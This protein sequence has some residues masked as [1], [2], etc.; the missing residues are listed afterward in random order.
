[1]SQRCV[2]FVR[3]WCEQDG[4]PQGV[5]LVFHRNKP[6]THTATELGWIYENEKW[7]CDK[8]QAAKSEEPSK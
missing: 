2:D 5:M 8:C 4:C 1:M 7:C 6:V 3:I